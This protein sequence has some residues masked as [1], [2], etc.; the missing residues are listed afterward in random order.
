MLKKGDYP[1]RDLS[2]TQTPARETPA[3]LATRPPDAGWRVRQRNATPSRRPQGLHE[4]GEPRHGDAWDR[5]VEPVL[6]RH[7]DTHTDTYAH[8]S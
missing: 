6:G 2:G 1:Q 7:A 4:R 3:T 8:L 5:A